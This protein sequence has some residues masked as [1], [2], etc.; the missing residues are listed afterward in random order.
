MRPV[1][2]SVC[3]AV[4]LAAGVGHAECGGGNSDADIRN[5]LAQELRDSDQRINAVYKAIL[6]R[7]DEGGK[8]SMRD[9]QRAWLKQRDQTC[10]LDT[11]ESDRERWLQ[12]ILADQA[13]TVCVVRFTFYRVGVLNDMLKQSGGTVDDAAA[14]PSAPKMAPASADPP[15]NAGAVV[16]RDEGYQL[17]SAIAHDKGK[18]YYEMRIDNGGIAALGDVLLTSGF[19][20]E[21]MA[22]GGVVHLFNIRHTRTDAAPVL[23]GWAIDLD[24]GVASV[25]SNGIWNTPPG[26]AGSSELKLNRPYV[27][28]LEGSSPLEP[29][30]QR[31]LLSLNLGEK[32]FAY[33]LPD[34][35]RPF[36][37][38]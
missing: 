24:N 34:G 4:A 32:P 19:A 6:A 14:A 15:P 13:K 29:L 28:F 37:E 21:M 18:W 26:S 27:A 1:I 35:Y 3:L 12:A 16:Y 8:V 5:C 22:G 23:V 30:V 36:S 9:Q 11:K 7:R 38:R 20:A 33:A 2:G 10:G 31:G 17:Q 25:R